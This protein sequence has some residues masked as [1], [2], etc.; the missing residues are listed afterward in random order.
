[1]TLLQVAIATHKEKILRGM[2]SNQYSNNEVSEKRSNFR[3]R[4]F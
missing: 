2:K 1:M 3:I 4:Q